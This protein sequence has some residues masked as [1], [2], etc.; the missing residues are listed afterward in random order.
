MV[1]IVSQVQ[2]ECDLTTT[3]KNLFKNYTNLLSSF[4]YCIRYTPVIITN[5][6]SHSQEAQ[7][8]F[9]RRWSPKKTFP[10]AVGKPVLAT[11]D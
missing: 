2:N 3:P 6:E 9:L 8:R 11:A 5:L 10:G 1:D 7:R 4:D